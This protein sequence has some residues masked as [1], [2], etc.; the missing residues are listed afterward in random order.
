MG[1]TVAEEL[2]DLEEQQ[3]LTQEGADK[4]ARGGQRSIYGVGCEEAGVERQFAHR[5]TA[6][7]RGRGRSGSHK[8]VEKDR[9]GSFVRVFRERMRFCVR[10]W[11]FVENSR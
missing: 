5:I 11:N 4:G 3:K 8:A 9:R 6:G 2:K 10:V 7:C 1:Q